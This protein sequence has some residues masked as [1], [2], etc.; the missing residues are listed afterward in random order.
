MS[1]LDATDLGFSGGVSTKAG[2][3]SG[4]V[5]VNLVMR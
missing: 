4:L 5:A 2:L 3:V 1:L